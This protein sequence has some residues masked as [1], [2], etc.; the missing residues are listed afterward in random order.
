MLTSYLTSYFIKAIHKICAIL[1]SDFLANRHFVK[2][3]F[4]I[5]NNLSQVLF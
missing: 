1:G 3:I 4:Q 5:M 2:N